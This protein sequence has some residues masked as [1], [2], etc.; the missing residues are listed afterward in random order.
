MK[1]GD[2]NI[3]YALD[4]NVRYKA[5]SGGI[6]TI[7][8]KYLLSLPEYGTSITFIFDTK[9]C[10]YIPQFIYSINEIRITGSIYHDIDIFSYIKNNINK[11]K[12]G[13]VLTCPPCQVFA[14]RKLLNKNNIKNFILSF[15]C[16]GQIT[17]EGTWCF[18]RFVGIDK[19][20]VVNMQ[21]RG[22]GWP[23]GIQISTKDGKLFKFTNYSE[24]W[25]SIHQSF[26][27]QPKRCFYCKRDSSSIA[28]IT[29]ADPWL[30]EYLDGD[31]IGNTLFKAN[32]KL[33]LDILEE[34]HDN[35]M[36]EYVLSCYDD[37]SIAQSPNILKERRIQSN[38]LYYKILTW[39][40]ANKRYKIW[41]T[42]S[43]G[44][45]RFHNKMFSIIKRMCRINKCYA[46]VINKFKA[47]IPYLRAI[48]K[49]SKLGGCKNGFMLYKCVEMKNSK[50]IYIGKNVGIGA[51]TFLGPITRHAGITYNPKII[52]GDGTWIGKHCS[53]AAI[54]KVQIGK[55][56]LFAGY[57]HI[58]DHSHG[59]ED[60]SKPISPQRLISKGPVIIDDNCWLGYNCEILS[61]VHIGEHSVIAARAVVTKDVPA[62]CIVA[63]NPAKIVKKYNFKSQKWEK[64]TN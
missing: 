27:F 47:K 3:G 39:L 32:T 63:G 61:G 17:I 51:Y 15:S 42:K 62:Y 26:L 48:V 46:Y 50:C 34:A 30:K 18:Y 44:R 23:S 9:K 20:N 14:I 10:M 60:I 25:K 11:I 22:N 6:G 7:I 16:S 52:I 53:I 38:K 33:G 35:K 43:Y 40:T 13:I 19:N 2:Y 36:F 4:Y 58:T 28:D 37:Y 49:S 64:I 31:K 56:V 5:S 41:V 29:L 59:Y 21:Y 45:I 8:S 12:D 1:L 57:V 55:N 24:P 54:H